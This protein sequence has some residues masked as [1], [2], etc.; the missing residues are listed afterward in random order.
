MSLSKANNFA[1]SA[2][3]SNAIYLPAV[4]PG[5]INL[6]QQG[7]TPL[8]ELPANF[9]LA[10]L[11]FWT[12]NSKLFNHKFCL[13]SVGSQKIGANF[14]STLFDRTRGDYTIVGDSGGY[15]IGKGSLKGLVNLRN[16]MTGNAA[17]AAWQY[18]NA[19]ARRWITD[20]L[21]TYFDYSMTIDMALWFNTKNGAKSPFHQCTDDQ[22][23]QMTL[24]NLQYI[25]AN[26]LGKTKWLN[27]LQ[28]TNPQSTIKWWDAV[29]HFKHGGWSLAGAT[30]WRGGLH[31]MLMLLLTMRDENAFDTGQDWLHM[32]GVSQPVWH[33]YFT[34]CQ[35]KLR[36][37]ANPILQF[38]YDSASPFILAGMLD[39]Y[40]MPPELTSDERSWSVSFKQL[41]AVKSMANSDELAF[42]QNISPLG[43]V[44]QMKHLVIKPQA[45]AG[46]R[47]DDV[48]N[49]LM[50][51]HNIWVYLDAG[52]R[53][54]DI[55][56]G[57]QQD[58]S[59]IPQS[60]LQALQV[61][62]EAFDVSSP[63]AFIDKHKAL[64]D[65]VAPM[66]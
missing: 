6:T 24:G 16:G 65:A 11:A 15:Q 9:D 37:T 62:E 23:I 3:Y 25:E 34:A 13:H 43:R 50:A 19:E 61:V 2:P 46:R 40:A 49:Q 45:H 30:G 8:R 21:S 66:K 26:G 7:A 28:G 60:H 58:R 35:N 12:G 39:Q 53:V 29:K 59:R 55:A 51:N 47:V 56:F 22:L 64:L 14:T 54:Y 10:D 20:S 1:L 38:S 31:N 27:V 63:M 4:T 18:D 41:N 32:L 33:M 52:Q 48:S 57:A 5:Y 42:K 44:L 17:F 36:E